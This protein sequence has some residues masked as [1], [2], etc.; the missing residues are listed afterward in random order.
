MM[1]YKIILVDHKVSLFDPQSWLS[2]LIKIFTGSK[3]NHSALLILD[4]LGNPLSV[5]EAR[6]KGVLRVSWQDWLSYREKKYIV[7]T[8]PGDIIDE[9]IEKSL[10]LKYDILSLFQQA[11][12]IITGLWVGR[13]DQGL[14]NCAEVCAWYYNIPNP[15]LVVP[16][17]FLIGQIFKIKTL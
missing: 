2:G 11:F 13:K 16:K 9:R 14:V 15:H 7:L 10:G 17:D 8:Y 5:V 12:Y 4:N 3:Y 6:G 1:D